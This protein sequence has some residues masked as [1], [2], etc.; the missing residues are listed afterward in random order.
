[1]HFFWNTAKPFLSGKGSHTSKTDL[2]NRDEVISDESTPAET[3]SKFFENAMENLGI[4][5]EINTITYFE[6]SDPVD[7]TLSK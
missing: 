2:V 7:I 6:S 1:M 3:F 4:R 5:E